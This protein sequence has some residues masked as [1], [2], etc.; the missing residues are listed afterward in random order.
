MIVVMSGTSRGD[1]EEIKLV[2]LDC[3][4]CTV[5][6]GEAFKELVFTSMAIVLMEISQTKD[7][8]I[9]EYI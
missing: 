9:F 4:G 2:R 8:R 7:M 1:R 3:P 5:V 6:Y